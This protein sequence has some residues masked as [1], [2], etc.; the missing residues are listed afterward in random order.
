M[1]SQFM[2]TFH[3]VI[4]RFSNPYYFCNTQWIYH[5]YLKWSSGNDPRVGNQAAET[6][7]TNIRLRRGYET[8][9]GA[10]SFL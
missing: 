2:I 3:L 4:R 6:I 9:M 7:K 5:E 1:F 8:F 10:I